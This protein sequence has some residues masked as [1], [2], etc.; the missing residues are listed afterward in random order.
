MYI[1]SKYTQ[2]MTCGNDKKRVLSLYST[3]TQNTWRRGL[4]LG[5]A[6]DARILGWRYEHVGIFW[7]YL[8]LK[9]ALAP[10]QKIKFALVPTPTPDASQWNIGGVGPS[11]IG[12][13][14]GHVHF[15]L[16]MSISFASGTQCKLVFSVEYRLNSL[17]S[18]RY[19]RGVAEMKFSSL[20]VQISTIAPVCLVRFREENGEII[21][22]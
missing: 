18:K 10:T 2:K 15:M 14:V 7:R 16:F 1:I 17:V 11:G 13:G 9:F 4:A 19:M 6:P 21:D 3:A 12:T 5:N 20:F 22:V 8:M